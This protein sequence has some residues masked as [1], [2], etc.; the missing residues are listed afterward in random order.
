MGWNLNDSITFLLQNISFL[1]RAKW[2]HSTKMWRTVRIHWQKLWIIPLWPTLKLRRSHQHV[3]AGREL[4]CWERCSP[5]PQTGLA[6]TEM[7][8]RKLFLQHCSENILLSST[9]AIK[10]FSDYHKIYLLPQQEN[11]VQNRP[12]GVST[13]P[14]CIWLEINSHQWTHVYSHNF[15]L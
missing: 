10:A 15:C 11:E 12:S 8:R 14:M 13:W 9:S 4:G 5:L 2:L 6:G 1:S 3:E 7:L